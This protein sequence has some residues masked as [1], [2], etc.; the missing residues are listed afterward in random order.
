MLCYTRLAVQRV[1]LS[2]GNFAPHTSPLDPSDAMDQHG[3][4]DPGLEF[5]HD[6]LSGELLFAPTLNI[7]APH[8]PPYA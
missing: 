1:A 7:L 8:T 3:G 6:H 5:R 2:R 4:R